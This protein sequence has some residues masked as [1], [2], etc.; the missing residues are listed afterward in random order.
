MLVLDQS[1]HGDMELVDAEEGYQHLWRK[2][3]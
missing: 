2:V 1:S 3:P